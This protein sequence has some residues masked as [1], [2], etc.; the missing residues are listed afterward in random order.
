M[1]KEIVFYDEDN[2]P[3]MAP[4]NYPASQM[5]YWQKVFGIVPSRMET[6]A[7][8]A[9]LDDMRIKKLVKTMNKKVWR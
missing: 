6:F 3:P 1:R 5:Q 8:A 9:S 7:L 2:L 4:L